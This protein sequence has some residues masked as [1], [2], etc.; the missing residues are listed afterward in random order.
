M[1]VADEMT[2]RSRSQARWLQTAAKSAKSANRA[3]AANLASFFCGS[4]LTQLEPTAKKKRPETRSAYNSTRRDTLPMAFR[5][6]RRGANADNKGGGGSITKSLDRKVEALVRE[7][8]AQADTKGVATASAAEVLEYVQARDSSLKRMKRAQVEKF[9]T[10]AVAVVEQEAGGG[11]ARGDES[12][13]EFDSDFEAFKE[14]VEKVVETSMHLTSWHYQLTPVGKDNN[15]ANKRIVEMWSKSSA[16]LSSS[17]ATEAAPEGQLRPVEGTELPKDAQTPGRRKRER[18]SRSEPPVKKQ[19]TDRAPPTGISLRD[20]GGIEHILSDIHDLIDMPL[21]CAT[22]YDHLGIQIPR[23]ILLH[24]PPGCGKTMLAN[25]IAAHHGVPFI[26]VSAPSIVSGMSGESEKKLREIFEEAVKLAPSIIFIDEIDAVMPKRDSAQREMEKR[27]VAQMLTCMDDL[28]LSKTGGNP[29]FVIGATNRPDSLDPALR[30]AG[31][32]DREICLGVPDEAGREKI[33]RVLSDKLKLSGDFDFRK[34]AKLTPGFVGADLSSLTTAA[35]TVAIKRIYEE[36]KAKQKN[37]D[38]TLDE[39]VSISNGAMDIDEAPK[40]AEIKSKPT[41]DD[42]VTPFPPLSAEELERLSITIDDFLVALP[43]VQP[44][45]KREGFATVPDVTWQQVGALG[46]IRKQMQL[47]IVKP[48]SHPEIFEAVG[49]TA[50]AG[51]LLYGPPGCGK[52][53]LAKAVANE[54]NANFISVKGPELLNKWVGESERAV[55]QVFMRAR[56]SQPCVIFFDELDALAGKRED[57]TTEATS[58]VVNTLL[59]ELDGLNDRKGVYVI[60]ATNRP[61]MIDPA[62]LRP[63]RLDKALFVALPI[64]EERLDILKKLTTKMPLDGT[65]DLW[66]IADDNR[67]KNFSGADLSS[68]VREAASSAVES[69][70]PETAAAGDSVL[71]S[72]TADPIAVSARDF[73][74]AF[75]IVRPSVSEAER[76]RYAQM[77]KKLLGL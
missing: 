53:L 63:G 77:N 70:F 58:R 34:L 31:R 61:D 72:V 52:T 23:G 55:R 3:A 46:A 64:A 6:S 28:S 43:K 15:S 62:M 37:N 9:V 40:S 27:I 29:V 35:G 12:G 60:A 54:S 68:L 74:K 66:K 65:I 73:E 1:D 56:A 17:A 41:L 59:T 11:G 4:N 13:E 67:C 76:L 8:Y 42:I 5:P 49:I 25:A 71:R 21:N 7:Y 51:V 18:S 44:S 26:P 57:S 19:K 36:L 48:I 30:R 10:K 20:I 39:G 2:T 32:F 22:C 69:F 16:G 38:L 24:G 50:P 45:S 47:A 33:L 14:A 75:G